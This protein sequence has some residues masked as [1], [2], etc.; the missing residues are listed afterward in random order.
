MLNEVL[1]KYL[2]YWPV[3]VILMAISMFGAWFYLRI[4]P[5]MYEA[6]ASILLK[7]ES[8]DYGKSKMDQTLDPLSDNKLIENEVVVLKS[9]TIMQDVIKNLGLYASFFE[10]GEMG[11]RP[12]YTT[13]PVMIEAAN[14]DEI[15]MVKKMPFT[16]SESDSMVIIGSKKYALDTFVKTDYGVIKFVPNK[17]F[18]TAALK[19]LYF[20]M[21]RPKVG[22]EGYSARLTI[23]S[24]K[25]NTVVTLTFKD[26]VPERAEDV[27]NEVI[28]VYNK[29]TLNDK[30]RL[31]S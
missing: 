23:G 1:F 11:P 15:K 21:L 6:T 2:P 3:F 28:A 13:S 8:K 20:S 14:P 22:A 27:L 9:K 18:Q 29:A 10:E 4:T 17:H 24:T 5:P 12:A 26:G 30:M 25:Q 16:F 31:A 19:P 7:D